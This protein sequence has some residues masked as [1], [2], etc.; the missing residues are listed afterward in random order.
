M[1]KGN[2]VNR[3][4]AL[5]AG[6]LLAAGLTLPRGALAAAVRPKKVIVAGAGI[7]GLSAAYELARRGHEVTVLEASRRTGGHVKTIRDPLP[8]GL[9]ADVGAENFPGRPAYSIVWDYIDEFGL[10]ALAWD[11]HK[12]AH[13]KLGNRWVSDAIFRDRG[14]LLKL[15]FTA[16][17]ADFVLQHGLSELPLLYFEKYLDPLR[18]ASAFPSVRT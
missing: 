14:E 5:K 18:W 11:R 1:G 8:G 15:G 7:A 13:R 16:R 10:K 2:A 4:E 3:R 9:Y 17:E 6:A 12:N